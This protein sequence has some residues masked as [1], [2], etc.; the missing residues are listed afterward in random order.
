VIEQY[1]V[2]LIGWKIRM[3]FRKIFVLWF[4]SKRP[5]QLFQVQLFLKKKKR[6]EKCYLLTN[7]DLFTNKLGDLFNF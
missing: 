6:K 4:T 2:A 1:R 7:Y 3:T 5:T